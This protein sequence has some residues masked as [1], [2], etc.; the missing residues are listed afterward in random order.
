MSKIISRE[1]FVSGHQ[2]L[3]CGV[4]GATKMCDECKDLQKCKVCSII[5]RPKFLFHRYYP[6]KKGTVYREMSVVIVSPYP[7]HSPKLCTG[8]V[9]W[10]MG[11]KFWC[12][13]CGEWFKNTLSNYKTNGNFC[14][15]CLTAIASNGNKG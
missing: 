10:E 11:M 15:D 4:F 6:N 12:Y 13:G 14:P 9:N 2:C 7:E 8:C 1:E 3:R 5:L